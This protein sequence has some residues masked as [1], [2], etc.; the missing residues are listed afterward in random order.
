MTDCELLKAAANAAGI[1]V[2]W[3]VMRDGATPFGI[4]ADTIAN[5]VYTVW[6]PLT[7][8]GD[9]LRL[10]VKLDIRLTPGAANSPYAVAEWWVRPSLTALDFERVLVEGDRAAALRRAGVMA[11]AAIGAAPVLGAA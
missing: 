11:A 9:L 1:D 10:A 6:S 4:L 7:D 5:T 2:L 3:P 8:D